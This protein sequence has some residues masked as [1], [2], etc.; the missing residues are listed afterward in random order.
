MDRIR[1]VILSLILVRNF[2]YLRVIYDVLI[3]IVLFGLCFNE[4]KLLL[5]KN[6]KKK[7][8]ILMSKCYIVN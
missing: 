3:R 4:N 6:S 8:L 1:I 5:K 7:L 2:V